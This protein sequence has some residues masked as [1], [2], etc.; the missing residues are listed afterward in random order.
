MSGRLDF[1]LSVSNETSFAKISSGVSRW[2]C[3]TIKS[4]MN[5]ALGGR[6]VER[7]GGNPGRKDFARGGLHEVAALHGA[8]WGREGAPAGVVE[9]L[10][11]A[12]DRLLPDDAG[13][14]PFLDVA[15]PVD[16]LPVARAQLHPFR[17]RVDDLN[18]VGEEVPPLIG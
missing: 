4:S 5:H 9:A 6:D 12:E 16:D 15:V 3:F 17:P 18:R 11:G 13:A 2:P 1:E 10:A 7:E 14:A 8:A